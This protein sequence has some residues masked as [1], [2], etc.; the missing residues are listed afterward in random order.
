VNEAFG[1]QIQQ[2]SAQFDEAVRRNLPDFGVGHGVE[3]P[4]FVR[5]IEGQINAINQRFAPVAQQLEPVGIALGAIALLSV[6]G[7]LV[8]QA[9]SEDG[10]DNGLSVLGSSQDGADQQKAA[11]SS[12]K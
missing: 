9:C 2:I 3:K 8:A 7:V 10:F 5:E 4:E 1:P 12:R 11:T 6:T